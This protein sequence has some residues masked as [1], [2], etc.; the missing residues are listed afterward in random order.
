VPVLF[1]P[2]Q[3]ENNE[4]DELPSSLVVAVAVSLLTNEGTILLQNRSPRLLIALL[5]VR[6]EGL[7]MFGFA[8]LLSTLSSVASI[9]ENAAV[10]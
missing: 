4:Q 3:Q 9:P 5:R 2:Q 8:V 6:P 7:F 10:K 1:L